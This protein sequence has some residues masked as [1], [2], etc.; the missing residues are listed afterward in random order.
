MQRR[1]YKRIHSDIKVKFSCDN[2]D[3]S[4]TVNNLSENGMFISTYDMCFPFDSRFEVV[5]PL[6]EIIINIPVKVSRITKTNSS[7]DGIAVEI[8]DPP[9]KYL[10]YISN[11]RASL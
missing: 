6:D 3:Y 4:G 1:T 8:L 9:E 2:L 11:L 5:L 7:Y 10:E